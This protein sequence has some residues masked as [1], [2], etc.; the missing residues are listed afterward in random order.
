MLFW[1]MWKLAV[2]WQTH[3]LLGYV[4]CVVINIHILNLLQIYIEMLQFRL[5]FPLYLIITKIMGEP[6][7]ELTDLLYHNVITC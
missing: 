7:V 2:I 1:K 3:L 4:H 5:N 6:V